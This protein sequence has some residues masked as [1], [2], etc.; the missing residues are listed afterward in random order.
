M[1]DR[2]RFIGRS[3]IDTFGSGETIM[4]DIQTGRMVQRVKVPYK[5][6][7]PGDSTSDG[8]KIICGPRMTTVNVETGSITEGATPDS[9]VFIFLLLA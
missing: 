1:N 3:S 5:E 7:N 2:F 9:Q 6:V 8:R 4:W